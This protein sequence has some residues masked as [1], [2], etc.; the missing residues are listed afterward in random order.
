M[1]APKVRNLMCSLN[2]KAATVPPPGRSTATATPH[3]HALSCS[4][5]GGPRRFYLPK[6]GK[7]EKGRQQRGTV[8]QVPVR[9]GVQDST[10]TTGC[11]TRDDAVLCQQ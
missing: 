9:M 6:P 7:A 11:R 5:G 8:K 10:V 1:E 4:E 3:L 2:T